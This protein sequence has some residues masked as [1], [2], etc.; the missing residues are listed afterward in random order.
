MG[1]AR[2]KQNRAIQQ[3]AAVAGQQQQAQSLDEMKNQL[4]EFKKNLEEFAVKH[5]KEI[6]DNPLFRD[7][8]MK[9]C[10]ETGVD[11]LSSTQKTGIMSSLFSTGVNDF[12]YEL[13]I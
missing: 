9:M 7:E 3:K 5:K 8:F 10:K 2:A 11:P 4:V 12:Y 6:N 1:M 13:A